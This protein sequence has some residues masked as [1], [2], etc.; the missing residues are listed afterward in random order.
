MQ[1]YTFRTHSKS[2]RQKRGVTRGLAT[3]LRP[4]PGL[5]SDSRPDLEKLIQSQNKE[6]GY[7]DE[8]EGTE[9]NEKDEEDGEGDDENIHTSEKDD[10]EHREREGEVTGS[11]SVIAN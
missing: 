1:H 2:T 8:D 9:E 7:D 4:D 5:T 3:H 10:Q 11:E 6:D